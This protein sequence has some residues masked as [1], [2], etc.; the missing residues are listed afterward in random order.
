MG[1]GTLIESPPPRVRST[2]AAELVAAFALGSIGPQVAA[3]AGPPQ[4]G[5]DIH[6]LY[7]RTV[8]AMGEAT[9]ASGA[10]MVPTG[11]AAVCQGARPI[12]L[13]AHGTTTNRAFDIANF[14][15][16]DNAEGPLIA[17]IFASQGYIVVAPNYAGYD[18]STLGYHPYLHADQ[19]S[20]DMIDA[21]TAARTALP[22]TI[23][24]TVRDSGKLFITGYSQGGY[25]AMATHRAMQSA[26]MAVT[27]SA[28]MSGPY[29]LAAFGDIV[30]NG[31]VD[32]GAPIFFVMVLSGYQRAYGNLYTNTADVFSAGYASGIDTLL[33]S[34]SSRGTLYAEGRLPRRE[35]F[36]D[37]P[38]DPV[39]AAITPAT[40]P[41]EMAPVYALGFGPAALLTN[42]YRLGYLQDMQANPDGG[43]PTTTTGVPAATPAHPLR[44]A[45]KANDLRNWSPVSPVLLCAGTEDPTVF[46]SNTQLMQGYWALAAATAPVSVLDLDAAAADGERFAAIKDGF[47]AAK[48]LLA[49]TAVVAGASDGG[50]MAVAEAYHSSLVPPFCLAAARSFFGDF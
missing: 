11:A 18:R 9:T 16:P 1:R 15:D 46:Y 38:P 29:A 43:L 41:A 14:D 45:F 27:A 24:P 37:T 47:T 35:L 23:A 32:L 42:S 17:A 6:T 7:Y 40:L 39:Y 28:P 20:K 22:M 31:S 34:T 49:A 13:Y 5:I 33:P 30:F 25:V 10:L 44:Q 8:G 12:M 36:S 21:L 3:L 2:S 50:A 19:Q 48:N 26:G 4:C